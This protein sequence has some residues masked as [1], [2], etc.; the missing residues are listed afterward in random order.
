MTKRDLEA[1]VDEAERFLKTAR[2]IRVKFGNNSWG[3]MNVDAL[4]SGPSVAACKRA[5]LDLTRALAQLRRPS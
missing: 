1:A 4:I 2:E 5:S 3:V